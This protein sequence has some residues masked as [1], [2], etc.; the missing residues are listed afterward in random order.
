M[1]NLGE[2]ESALL[3]YTQ[4]K[5]AVIDEDGTYVYVN[6][7]ATRILGFEP[8]E[9]VGRNAF[10][11][12]HPE[13]V[14]RVWETFEEVIES[15]GFATTVV[16]Y[17][18]ETADGDYVWLESRCSNATNSSIGGYVV[19][20]R[21]VTA[22]VK[23]ERER[24]ETAERLQELAAQSTDVLWMF[25]DDW[26]ELLFVN[27]AYE[28]VYGGDVE[29]VQEDPTKFLDCVHPDDVEAV[30]DAMDR[31]S[32][33][34][35]VDLEYRVDPTRNFNTWA[36]VQAVPVVENDE[37]VRIVGFTRDVT[38][39][40]RHQ[41]QLVVIDN[42]LRH[43]LR[44]DMNTILGYADLLAEHT[45]GDLQEHA[46]LI[47]TVGTDLLETVQKQREIND[48]FTTP[49]RRERVDLA[50]VVSAA[51]DDVAS[52]YPDVDYTVDLPDQL[53]VRAIPHIRLAVEELV[54]NA[55]KHAA[56]DD[57]SVHVTARIEG[58]DAI[59]EIRD[60]CPP[61]PE[62]E[63][64]VLTGEVPMDQVTHTTG[65]GLWVAY[66]VVDLSDGT[67]EF[68]ERKTAGDTAGGS[69]GGTAGDRAEDSTG[70]TVTIRLSR[71]DTESETES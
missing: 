57:P 25:S 43:N 41:R 19:S 33:G 70:N 56:V 38:E 3:D 29:A 36:W 2:P 7:A 37:V 18:H 68:M 60:D 34:H 66:W 5:V 24:D 30:I 26:S 4:D 17:R 32:R 49:V 62:S 65:L 48:L 67:I 35:S 21:D 16:E 8:E 42:I 15:E 6:E 50:T 61:I 59:L 22:R 69:A 31:L 9:L 63:T 52:D 20:S 51:I 12:I 44:N 14:E 40:R 1:S 46:E 39:R 47:R 13:D 58:D 10:D 54:E 28:D 53:H 45:E 11:L 55:T 64:R 23:A 27:D 71:S